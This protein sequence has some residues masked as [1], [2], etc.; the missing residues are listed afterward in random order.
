MDNNRETVSEII[1]AIQKASMFMDPFFK[2]GMMGTAFL[3]TYL[4]RMAKEGKIARGEFNSVMDFMKSCDGKYTIVNVP[5]DKKFSPWE[6]KEKVI[7]DKR[8]YIVRNSSTGEVVRNKDGEEMTWTSEKK[9]EKEMIKRNSRENLVLEDLGKSGIRHVV[10]PDLNQN[11]QMV[12]IAFFNEDKERFSNWMERYLLSRMQGGEKEL[13]E[14]ENLTNGNTSLVSMPVEGE[15]LEKMKQDFQELKVNYAVLPDLNVGDGETQIMVANSDV[16]NV[17]FWLKIYNQ[18]LLNRGEKPVDMR[19]ISMPEYTHT[20]EISEE[21][22]ADTA[23]EELKKANEKYEGKSPGEAE[24][25][26]A[27][28]EKEVRSLGSEAYEQYK[29]NPEYSEISI[30]HQSLVN[31]SRYANSQEI[32]EKGIFACRIPGTYGEMELTLAIPKEQVFSQNDG[33]QYRAFLK[34]NERPM[35]IGPT[36]IRVPEEERKTGKQIHDEY[37]DPVNRKNADKKKDDVKT[38]NF[39]NFKKRDYNYS[40]LERALLKR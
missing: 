35:V 38:K 39:N 36:G 9:A 5:Y 13:R 15:T 10:M 16:P 33:R 37:F 7:N 27:E 32:A 30:D 23:S 31:N 11:D 6:V 20:G 19:N 8:E 29:N 26:I 21:Q 22:Y 2:I 1:I 14:L 18:D 12:Q 34:N 25:R 24:Q 3:I 17:E 28:Q 4:A 40:E